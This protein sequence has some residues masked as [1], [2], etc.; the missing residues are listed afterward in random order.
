MR[1]IKRKGKLVVQLISIFSWIMLMRKFNRGCTILSNIGQILSATMIALTLISICFMTFHLIEKRVPLEVKRVIN[2]TY[3]I[4]R[5]CL[6]LEIICVT[7]THLIS[8]L[9]TTMLN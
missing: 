2:C 9:L 1:L 6:Q 3:M 5:L 7:Y 4:N 8:I